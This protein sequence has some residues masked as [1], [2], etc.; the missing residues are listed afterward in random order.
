MKKTL[1]LLTLALFTLSFVSMGQSNTS[2]K[3]NVTDKQGK[4]AEAVT[5]TVLLAKDSSAV[6]L[7]STDKSGNFEFL[8][9][10]FGRFLLLYSF[11]LSVFGVQ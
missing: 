8:D 10:S 1:F 2:V 3:G 9:L 5:V 6:K 4:P 11:Y 7:Q